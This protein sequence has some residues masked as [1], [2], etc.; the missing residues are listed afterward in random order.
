MRARWLVAVLCLYQGT[1]TAAAAQG[2]LR[3]RIRELF[4]FG[5]CG[6]P[7]CLD[8]SVNATNGHGNHFLPDII[9]SNGAILGFL[10]DAIAT[11]ASNLPLSAT[12][13][14][15]TFRFVGG[16]P[17]RTS[18]SLGPVFGERA[19]T[20]GKG[21]L[22]VGA[23]MSALNFSSLRGV[24][25][26]GLILNFSHEDVEPAGLGQPIREN[27]VL[28]VRLDLNVNLLVTTFFTTWGIS[29]GIDVGLAIPVVHAGLTGRSTGQFFPLGIPTS[30]F[31][32]GDSANPV[33]SANA[34]TFGFAT[35]LG[36]IAVRLKGN[37]TSS[38]T[39]AVAFM[40]DARLPTGSE[41]DLTGSGHMSVRGLM[42]GSARFGDFSPH[43]NVG[44]LLRTGQDRNDALLATGGFDQPLS[45]W[46]TMAVDVIAEWQIG[47][48]GLQLPG[49]VQYE[50]PVARTVF[51]TNVP[52]MK[53]HRINGAFGMK[54]RIPGGA[55]LVANALVP[56][57][58]GGLESRLIW[59]LGLD[60]NF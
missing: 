25:L 9:A 29:D 6:S 32:A 21:R 28:Q 2:G 26:D 52:N 43:V 30:H 44:Y 23:N 3:D 37:L 18:T 20:L 60:G 35:G 5:S 54:F 38:E 47:Q 11:N 31:F 36:D 24:P 57:R 58:R 19:Q 7:L 55:I 4:S 45:E 48:S 34:A 42:L 8:N 39:A 40:A 46:A 59:T 14:G 51:P 50:Y 22:V 16:L 49:P 10:G 33:L 12:S 27:D 15:A 56:L 1:A 41:D 53:D 17:V 13:S